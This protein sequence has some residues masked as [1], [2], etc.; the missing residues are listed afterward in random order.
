[1]NKLVAKIATLS[2]E[3]LVNV[4][5]G[6]NFKNLTSDQLTVR[7]AVLDEYE[8][9]LGVDAVDALLDRLEQTAI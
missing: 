8:A 4:L 9:R 3:M 7:V 5:E 1:M 2:N 6:I